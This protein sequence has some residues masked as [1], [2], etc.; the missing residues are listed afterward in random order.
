MQSAVVSDQVGWPEGEGRN[1]EFRKIFGISA[2]KLQA[3][4]IDPDEYARK[5][6]RSAVRDKKSRARWM[7]DERNYDL[8]WSRWGLRAFIA[9]FVVLGLLIVQKAIPKLGSILDVM[10]VIGLI[11]GIVMVGL[12]LYYR[13]LQRKAQRARPRR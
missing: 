2:E 9:M 1:E 5:N 7:S 8:L 10:E 12:S 11:A 3:Q 6:I 4:G 13:R